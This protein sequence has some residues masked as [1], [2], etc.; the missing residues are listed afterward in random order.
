M[1][2][3]G[4]GGVGKTRLAAEVAARAERATALWLAPV[5]D[6]AGI[7]HALAAALDLHVVHRDVL[8]CVARRCWRRARS[9]C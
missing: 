7:A 3:I 8:D 5:T 9:C 6:A 1:T 4:T 2:V